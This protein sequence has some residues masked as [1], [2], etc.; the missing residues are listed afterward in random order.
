V[1]PCAR[2]KKKQWTPEREATGP[3]HACG[4]RCGPILTSIAASL[5]SACTYSALCW[6]LLPGFCQT[7]GLES[8]H[9]MAQPSQQDCPHARAQLRH[10]GR[11][12]VTGMF[13]LQT[14]LQR[15]KAHPQTRYVQEGCQCNWVGGNYLEDGG[16]VLRVN[17]HISVRLASHMHCHYQINEPGQAAQS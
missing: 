13:S 4:W 17:V 6:E 10:A 7:C 3:S 15:Q 2:Q 12:A 8:S 1:F 16:C 14:P 5:S 9:T 11:G